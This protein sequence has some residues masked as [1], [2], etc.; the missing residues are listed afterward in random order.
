VDFFAGQRNGVVA[1]AWSHLGTIGGDGTYKESDL[2]P[3]SGRT[4]HTVSIAS[5]QQKG[6]PTMFA[7]GDGAAVLSSTD[8]G[9]SWGFVNLG[10]APEVVAACGFRCSAAF[11][12]HVW[13]AGKPGGF[14]LHSAD[15]GKNWEIQKTGLA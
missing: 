8:G 2:D 11:G 1:G 14:V 13:V 12:P 4:L 5:T 7:A 15:A 6:Y 3:L 10:L 9:K